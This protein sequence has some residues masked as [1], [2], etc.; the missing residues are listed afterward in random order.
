MAIAAIHDW[1]VSRGPFQEGVDLLKAHGKPSSGLLY[2]LGLGESGMSRDRL[3]KALTEIRNAGV[4][5]EKVKPV[6]KKVVRIPSPNSP[7]AKAHEWSLKSE[8]GTDMPE[9]TLPEKLRPLRRQLTEWHRTRAYLRGATPRIPD[10]LE[11]REHALRIRDLRRKITRGWLILETFR[12]TGH[13]LPDDPD[14]TPQDKS[15]A[16]KVKRLNTLRTYISRVDNGKRQVSPEKYA[17]WVAER[18][19]LQRDIDGPD[20]EQ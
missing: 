2:V 15:L 14:Q 12:A 4:Q 16:A 11:L 20:Q 9:G 7:E 6:V 19:K 3:V 18:D 5:A 1:L 8:P 13:I 17:E 10:G